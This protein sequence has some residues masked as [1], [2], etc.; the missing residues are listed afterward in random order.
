MKY[1]DANQGQFDDM[2]LN[3]NI[4]GAAYKT[5]K[6]SFSFF[7]LPQKMYKKALKML[8]N[9]PDFMQG[10]Q[11]PQGDHSIFVQSGVPAIAVS[12][13]WFVEN[14]QSQDITHTPKDNIGVVDHNKVV[15]LAMALDKLIRSL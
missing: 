15:D 6:S 2:I 3:I 10:P 14:M 13:Q 4:D 11:W 7:D 12:S 5:G 1:I 9:H 8:D